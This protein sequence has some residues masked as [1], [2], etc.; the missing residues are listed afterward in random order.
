MGFLNVGDQPKPCCM[1]SWLHG[2]PSVAAGDAAA[3]P[4]RGGAVRRGRRRGNGGAREM[5]GAQ[6]QRGE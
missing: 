6:L 2:T 1:A 3:P 5:P 4:L